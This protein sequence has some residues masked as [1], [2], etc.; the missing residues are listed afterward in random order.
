MVIFP[1]CMLKMFSSNTNN[2]DYNRRQK[3]KT[4]LEKK[5]AYTLSAEHC[6][7]QLFREVVND[8][9]ETTFEKITHSYHGYIYE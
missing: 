5:G 6:I 7:R 1:H 3:Q 4:L 9:S 2:S 8:T